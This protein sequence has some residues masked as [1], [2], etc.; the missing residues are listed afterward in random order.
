MYIYIYVCVSACVCV[1]ILYIAIIYVC[2][3]VL[4][5][6]HRHALKGTI[7]AAPHG[8]SNESTNSQP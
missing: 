3:C 4:L 2:R 6:F 7:R 1:Y 5:A 8:G